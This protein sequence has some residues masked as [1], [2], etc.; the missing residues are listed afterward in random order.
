MIKCPYCGYE[1]KF[2]LIKNWRFRFYEVIMI[3]CPKCN[4]VFNHYMGV[5][6]KGKASE[7]MIK[8]KPRG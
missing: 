6:A 8:V 1:G 5:N 4:G 7:F 3:N 2:I